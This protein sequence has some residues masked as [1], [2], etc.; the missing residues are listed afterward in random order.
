MR[1]T[2]WNLTLGLSLLLVANL[3][4]NFSVTTASISSL[5]L[6]KDKTVSQETS[7]FSTG[8]TIYAVAVISN[9]PGK[10]KVKGRLVVEDVAG[11]QI[12]PIP[13][14]ETT[15]DLAGSGTATFTF[16]P[17]TAGWPKGKY[18]VEALM[19]DENGVQKDQKAASYTVS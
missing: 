5:K 15:L 6:G 2:R 1:T 14:L 3:A 13:D 11:Q 16:S 10:L 18:K 17:P 7:S 19:L 9:A 4:C 12:G 8:D